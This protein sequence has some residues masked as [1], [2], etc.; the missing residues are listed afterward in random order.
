[1]KILEKKKCSNIY[2]SEKEFT[3]EYDDED[4]EVWSVSFFRVERYK[5]SFYVFH[6]HYLP[7]EWRGKY[8]YAR[9]RGWDGW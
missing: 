7:K 3:T 9:E 1:M 2:D 5:K 8:F 6:E 4:E